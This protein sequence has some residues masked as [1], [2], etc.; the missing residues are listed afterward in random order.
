MI[1]NSVKKCLYK[2][3]SNYYFEYLYD[4]ENTSTLTEIDMKTL[5][6]V[7][8]GKKEKINE[9]EN[10][11]WNIK[12]SD[13]DSSFIG[14]GF[15]SEYIDKLLEISGE[16]SSGNET[17]VI[18]EYDGTADYFVSSTTAQII[19]LSDG[20]KYVVDIYA[21]KEKNIYTDGENYFY[22]SS[23]TWIKVYLYEKDSI[24]QTGASSSDFRCLWNE[25]TKTWDQ[26]N[27]YYSS[28]YYSET[29]YLL[30]KKTS[31]SDWEYYIYINGEKIRISNYVSTSLISYGRMYPSYFSSYLFS[32]TNYADNSI[33]YLYVKSEN[34]WVEFSGYTTSFNSNQYTFTAVKGDETRTFVYLIDVTEKSYGWFEVSDY[35][36]IND[37]CA[38]ATLV[39]PK[40]EGENEYSFVFLINNDYYEGDYPNK[41]KRWAYG[42]I[43]T[44]ETLNKIKC[45]Y[46]LDAKYNY[47]YIEH[48]VL[49]IYKTVITNS[50]GS[51]ISDPAF[52]FYYYY[53]GSINGDVIANYDSSSKDLIYRNTNR[54]VRNNMLD[55]TYRMATMSEETLSFASGAIS[56]KIFNEKNENFYVN[57]DG[58][59]YS[60]TK[61]S[62]GGYIDEHNHLYFGNSYGELYYGTGRTEWRG[63][64]TLNQLTQHAIYKNLYYGQWIDSDTETIYLLYAVL[65]GSSYVYSLSTTLD[66]NELI[67]ETTNDDGSITHSIVTYP[68]RTATT[69]NLD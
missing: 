58:S 55:G 13:L 41:G 40:L 14:S 26:I 45:L 11:S 18:Y 23:G 25:D 29:N 12:T 66:I 63:V 53:D 22:N 36:S 59:Y 17:T 60:L 21:D 46:S 7:V 62:Y 51:S 38:Y 44:N 28:A 69:V 32:A 64:Y 5:N 10:A 34:G 57:E 4:T 61:D 54:Y 48:D 24:M 37:N 9:D 52:M 33:R 8:I 42:R 2:R 67:T 15:T 31:D 16:D 39:S 56:L 35:V 68:S 47:A 65:N 6:G 43:D 19:Q 30:Y 3:F 1:E 27:T 20:D 49:P 50:T